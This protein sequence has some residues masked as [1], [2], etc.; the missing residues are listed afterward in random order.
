MFVLCVHMFMCVC[1]FVYSYICISVCAV[2]TCMYAYASVDQRTTLSV[3]P[4]IPS[5]L[6][7]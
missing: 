5:T 6:L 1:V 4:Q 2:D 3:I 7:F